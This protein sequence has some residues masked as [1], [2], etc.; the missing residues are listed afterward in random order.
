MV[1]NLRNMFSEAKRWYNIHPYYCSKPK[2]RKKKWQRWQQLVLTVTGEDGI[3]FKRRQKIFLNYI[4][5]GNTWI[6][7]RYIF[8]TVSSRKS[9]VSSMSISIYSSYY[10]KIPDWGTQ[11][12]CTELTDHVSKPGYHG[13]FKNKFTTCHASL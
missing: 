10:T 1:V 3:N 9:I 12:S 8:C 2:K 13:S 5:I 7:L 6:L 11:D 4:L